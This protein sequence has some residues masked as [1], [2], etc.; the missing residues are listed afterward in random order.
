MYS[1]PILRNREYG[2]GQD[3]FE[4]LGHTS[5]TELLEDLAPITSS[6]KSEGKLPATTIVVTTVSFNVREQ[7]FFARVMPSVDVARI[8]T[9]ITQY[10]C[11]VG[12]GWELASNGNGFR[13]KYVFISYLICLITV[14][15]QRLFLF[16]GFLEDTT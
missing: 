5:T 11:T 8:M 15:S 4:F 1:L 16:Y 10:V 3:A 2:V 7:F 9:A 6:L 12:T 14:S 13:L